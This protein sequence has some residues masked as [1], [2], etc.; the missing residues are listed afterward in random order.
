MHLFLYISL[1]SSR[2]EINP[3]FC[4]LQESYSIKNSITGSPQESEHWE[5]NLPQVLKKQIHFPF[6]CFKLK[7]KQ[8]K[9]IF[10]PHKL[11]LSR[12]SFANLKSFYHMFKL[13][14]LINIFKVLKL[15]KWESWITIDQLNQ[16]AS[17]LLQISNFALTY[18]LFPDMSCWSE[19][20]TI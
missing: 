11:M 10:S 19:D 5:L 1:V 9:F 7:I 4:I 18:Q 13:K 3:S 2:R 12:Y 17:T 14:W 8:R 20:V 16:A 6:D 15:P